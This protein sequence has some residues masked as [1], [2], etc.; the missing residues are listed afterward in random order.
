MIN[1]R[2][3]PLLLLT[4]IFLTSCGG[5]R[6]AKMGTTAP[7]DAAVAAVVASHYENEVDVNTMQGKLSL[8]YQTEERNQSVT[9]NFRMKKDETIW[10]SGQLLG[11]PLAKVMITPNSVQFYEKITG[12][13]F[14]GDFSLLS[15]LLGTPLDFQ[16]VQNLLLGQAIYD[17][18][19][20]RYK[21]TESTRG[22]QLE[23][24]NNEFLKRMF[25]LDAGNFKALAQQLGQPRENRSVTVT[26]PQYQKVEGQ[27]FP[28]QIQILANDGAENTRIDMT[29]RGIEFNVP[30]S[31]P[32]S[33]P[34]GYEEITIE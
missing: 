18:R 14:D 16:K 1:N 22:Y 7:E 24:V 12:T 32:F 2:I 27:L 19:D 29:F 4:L 13:Y 25:L 9:V 3:F 20:E 33:I 31:F 30:V 21:L 15:D 10:M 17:L 34:S 11:I 23:A 6:K 8:N 26:Y 28:G 5:A